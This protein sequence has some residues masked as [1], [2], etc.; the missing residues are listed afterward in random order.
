MHLWTKRL[1][2]M[3]ISD[4]GFNKR[5]TLCLKPMLGS[6]YAADVPD[7]E[8]CPKCDAISKEVKEAQERGCP[9]EE[10]PEC[11]NNTYVVEGEGMGWRER[12]GE[13]VEEHYPIGYCVACKH[14]G[15]DT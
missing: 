11:H 13:Q 10:C 2:K 8:M 7:R 5:G 14:N 12:D 3:H 9:I 6:N 1:D 15:E 4:G